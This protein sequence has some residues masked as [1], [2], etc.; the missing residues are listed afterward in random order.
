[1]IVIVVVVLRVF[2]GYILEVGGRNYFLRGTE[3]EVAFKEVGFGFNSD[4]YLNIVVTM[5]IKDVYNFLWLL[6]FII[7]G[8]IKAYAYSMVPYILADNPNIDSNRAIELSVEMTNGQKWDMFVLD[9]SFLGWYILGSLLFGIGTWFVN[10]YVDATKAQLYASLRLGAIKHNLC[11]PEELCYALSNAEESEQ[12]DWY[13][14][15]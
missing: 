3:R 10:P 5:F 11:T 9:L 6:L 7:P 2:L 13:D 8:I 12:N 1:M 4:Y 15:Y 14:E